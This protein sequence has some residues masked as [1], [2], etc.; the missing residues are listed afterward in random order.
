[1]G[2]FDLGV[3]LLPIAA[4]FDGFDRPPGER[5]RDH[6]E[7]AGNSCR[8]TFALGGIWSPR[9][10]PNQERELPRLRAADGERLLGV[11]GGERSIASTRRGERL[12]GPLGGGRASSCIV[13]AREKSRVASSTLAA[14]IVGHD[15]AHHFPLGDLIAEAVD[16]AAGQLDFEQVRPVALHQRRRC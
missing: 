15:E 1:M 12:L 7:R 11:L 5:Q 3:G 10:T 4:A 6:V 13:A 2:P 8:A 14:Q 16:H 9:W